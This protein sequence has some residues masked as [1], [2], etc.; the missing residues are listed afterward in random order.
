MCGLIAFAH[1]K[2]VAGR[3]KVEKKQD[4]LHRQMLGVLIRPACLGLPMTEVRTIPVQE[5]YFSWAKSTLQVE[6]S[7]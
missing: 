5:C 4:S 7:I 1:E 6:P 2:R 3:R